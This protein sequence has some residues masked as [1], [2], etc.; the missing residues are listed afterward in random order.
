MHQCAL[1][2]PKYGNIIVHIASNWIWHC[3]FPSWLVDTSAS[4]NT[5]LFYSYSNVLL[6]IVFLWSCKKVLNT[7]WAYVISVP[8]TTNVVSLNPTHGEVYSI[9][10]YVI[11]FVC[12]LRRGQWF[13]ST[14]IKLTAISVPITTNVVSSNPAHGEVY[15]IQHY[16]IKFVSDLRRGQ[17]FF[18][19][20]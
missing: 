3:Q 15:S 19:H 18:H 5:I 1:Y 13:F 16:V 14:P 4:S 8:I 20:Q 11:K 17:W 2:N 6:K 12:D 9:Q 7:I 10:H